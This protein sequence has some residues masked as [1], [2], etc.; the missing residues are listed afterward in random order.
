LEAELNSGKGG[1]STRFWLGY[2]Y[3][4]LGERDKAVAQFESYLNDQPRD[5]DVLYAVA[6]T[7]AELA[8]MS[9]ERIFIVAPDSARAHQMRG[10][11]FEL[12]SAWKEAIEQYRIAAKLDQSLV[13]VYAS[14]GRVYSEELKDQAQALAAYQAELARAPF[15][16]EANTFLERYYL[17]RDQPA[18]AREFRSALERHLPPSGDRA[19]GIWLAEDGRPEE[20]LLHLLRW[21]AAEP[22]NLDAYFY[23]GATFTDLKVKTIKRLKSV[24]PQSYRLHQ[25]LAESYVSIHKPADAGAEYRKVLDLAPNL[26]GVHYELARLIS[27]TETQRALLNRE[28]EIDPNHYMARALLGRIYVTL[29]QPDAAIPVLEQALKAKPDLIDARKALGQA[30]AAKRDFERALA[31][32]QM[33]AQKDPQDEQIHFLLS[34]AYRGLGN[35]EEASKELARHQQLTLRRSADSH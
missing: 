23:L 26:P 8:E 29:Q 28:L 27:D 22:G 10:I 19:L 32:Y 16:R 12:E 20:A 35:S 5:E 6:H 1:P 7:Y 13:G 4:A 18:R 3:L 2:T 17:S 15:S 21:R 9:L 14:V 11:R 25:I 31:C 33:V 34:Q 30:W 24:N